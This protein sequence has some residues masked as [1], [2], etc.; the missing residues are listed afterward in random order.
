MYTY[1]VYVGVFVS[2]PTLTTLIMN[3]KAEIVGNHG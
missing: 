3:I 2:I 1:T